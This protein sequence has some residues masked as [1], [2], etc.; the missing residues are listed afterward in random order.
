MI[1]STALL[2]IFLFFAIAPSPDAET[3]SEM[4]AGFLKADRNAALARSEF[5]PAIHA[6]RI[7][8]TK[9]QASVKSLTGAMAQNGL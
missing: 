8:L 7:K 5:N 4:T 2:T 6:I 3:M 1:N 9:Q